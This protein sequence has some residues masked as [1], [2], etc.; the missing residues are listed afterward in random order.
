VLFKSG[1]SRNVLVMSW[2][3]GDQKGNLLPLAGMVGAGAVG[4][5]TGL[6]SA[7]VTAGLAIGE[8]EAKLRRPARARLLRMV[9]MEGILT[10]SFVGLGCRYSIN[11]LDRSWIVGVCGTRLEVEETDLYNKSRRRVPLVMFVPEV[12]EIQF[13]DEQPVEQAP[14]DEG[15]SELGEKQE[16]MRV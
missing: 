6:Q 12:D 13:G 7:A 16:E 14:E 2:I 1:V 11:L 4:L 3:L 5:V 10:D 9:E 15:D 8:A